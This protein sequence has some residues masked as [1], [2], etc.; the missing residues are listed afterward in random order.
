M[1]ISCIIDEMYEIHFDLCSAGQP[2]VQ[3]SAIARRYRVQAKSQ[4]R[5]GLTQELLKVHGAPTL[6]N[7]I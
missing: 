7:H 4:E 2:A 5:D 3:P 6:T 1:S